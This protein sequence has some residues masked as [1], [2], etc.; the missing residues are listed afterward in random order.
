MAGCSSW[1]ASRCPF[2][3]PLTSNRH[4]SRIVPG[5]V[6][7]SPSTGKRGVCPGASGQDPVVRSAGLRCGTAPPLLSP[8]HAAQQGAAA[9]APPPRGLPGLPAG[10]RPGPGSTRR[11]PAGVSS[12]ST[13]GAQ[14][15][16]VS[17]SQ[18]PPRV[19][20]RS[21]S[22]FPGAVLPLPKLAARY[23]VASAVRSGLPSVGAAKRSA[24][25]SRSRFGSRR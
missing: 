6:T 1:S 12:G 3:S 8:G 25:A 18:H 5:A 24:F 13:G 7:T 10:G 20:F 11:P 9:D 14:L 17:V 22:W 19:S 4:G 16:A 2:C 23:S 15:S 21:E